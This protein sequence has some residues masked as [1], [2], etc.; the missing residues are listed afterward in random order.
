MVLYSGDLLVEEVRIGRN[1]GVL[2]FW[3]LHCKFCL[4]VFEI[5]VVECFLDFRFS[6]FWYCGLFCWFVGIV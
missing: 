6:N 1:F 4:G 2:C 5:F 3:Y